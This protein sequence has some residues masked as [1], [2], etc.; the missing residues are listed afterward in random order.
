[1]QA[2]LAVVALRYVTEQ[3]QYLAL[4][5]DG[6]RTVSLGGEIEPSDLGAFERSDRRDRCRLDCLLVGK[7]RSRLAKS[8][9]ALIQDQ[10]E[11]PTVALEASLDFMGCLAV[12]RVRPRPL[13]TRD[14]RTQRTLGNCP[15]SS[16]C[17]RLPPIWG[18]SLLKN[19]AKS[20]ANA[21]SMANGFNQPNRRNDGRSEKTVTIK[22]H[23]STTEVGG[24]HRAGGRHIWSLASTSDLV[25]MAQQVGRILV[26]A[27]GTGLSA[28][29][30]AH[31]HRSE[32]HAQRPASDRRQHVPDGVSH[33]H[34]G[35][36]G[37]AEPLGG[38]E[39]RSGSGLA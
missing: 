34:G 26:D 36:D 5:I 13:A 29:R 2:C 18:A 12:G 31:S 32:T 7:G 37:R 27:E 33:N 38:G 24:D 4:F 9:F 17:H 15:G 20:A 35:V 10:N 1:M 11:C 39:N 14:N 25:D 19:V 6:N 23:A 22:S 30:R 3:A 8:L 28:A 16:W 21:A